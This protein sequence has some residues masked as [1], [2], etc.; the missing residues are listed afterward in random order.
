MAKTYDDYLESPEFKKARRLVQEGKHGNRIKAAYIALSVMNLDKGENNPDLYPYINDR[1]LAAMLG[2]T[3]EAGKKPIS[4]QR[5]L[6]KEERGYKEIVV[7]NVDTS[8]M[9]RIG[10]GNESVYLYYFPTY[11]I[12]SILYIK[13]VD[14]SHET[15]IYRCKI[16][17]TKGDAKKRVSEQIGQQLPEKARIALVIKTDN[18]EALETKIHDELKRR[19]CWLDPKSGDDVVGEEWFLTNPVQVEEIFNSIHRTENSNE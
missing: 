4:D 2:M 9:K 11:E 13:Y 3:N 17:K 1:K 15:P 8:K 14:D 5:Q 19:R 16:G 18:C 12:N 6:L 7:K 10:R